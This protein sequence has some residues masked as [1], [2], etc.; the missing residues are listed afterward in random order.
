MS[1]LRCLCLFGSSFEWFIY[2]NVSNSKE[3]WSWSYGSWIYNKPCNQCLSLM[4]LWVQISIRETANIDEEKQ[5]KN[6]TQ[7]WK[8][9]RVPKKPTY[10]I[11]YYFFNP[12]TFYSNACIKPGKWAVMCVCVLELQILTITVTSTFCRY[13][14]IYC[15]IN[16]FFSFDLWMVY[17]PECKQQQRTMVVIVW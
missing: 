15:N 3:L 1:Y 7:Y 17:I 9:K 8:P 14:Y 13:V 5:S 6:T 11:V 16:T 12:A 10:I 4:M 2:Q